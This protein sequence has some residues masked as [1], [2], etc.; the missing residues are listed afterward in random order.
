MIANYYNVVSLNLSSNTIPC[1][2]LLVTVSNAA[3]TGK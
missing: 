2:I 3:L 1:N